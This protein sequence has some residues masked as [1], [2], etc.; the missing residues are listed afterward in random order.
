MPKSVCLSGLCQDVYAER[1][2]AYAPSAD[3]NHRGRPLPP[4]P[5]QRHRPQCLRDEYGWGAG[6][7]DTIDPPSEP[8]GM[9]FL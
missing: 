6:S 8:A 3:D 9:W 4:L 7:R 5:E 2:G 1:G